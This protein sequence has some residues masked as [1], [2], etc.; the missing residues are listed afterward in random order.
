MTG[1][2]L[3]NIHSSDIEEINTF[4]KKDKVDDMNFYG[5]SAYA[6]LEVSLN[7]SGWS[8]YIDFAA[9]FLFYLSSLHN[10]F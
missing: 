8:E 2:A 7:I 9:S 5:W 6:F 4:A 3:M 1:L 10:T